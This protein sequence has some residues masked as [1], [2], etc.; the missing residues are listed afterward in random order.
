MAQEKTNPTN[1][2]YDIALLGV[3]FGANYGSLLNGYSV[4]KILKKMNRTV[5]MVHKIGAIPND[6]EI[7]GTHNARFVEKFYPDED[8]SP[9]YSFERLSELNNYCD[10]F[11]TG[12]DQVWQYG[13]NS[14][15]HM[16]FF[17]GFVNSDKRKISFGTSFGHSEDIT[18]LEKRHEVSKWLSRF[19]AISVREESGITI[20]RDIYG[21][22]ARTVIE[23]VFCVEKNEFEKLALSSSINETEP[24]ILAYILDPTPEKRELIIKYSKLSG[25]KFIIIL[26]GQPN[27]YQK[28]LELMNL[29]NCLTGIGAEDFIK[30]YQN[31]DFVI[32][33]SFHGTAFSIIFNKPFISIANR[34]RGITRFEDL[35][36][37]FGLMERLIYDINVFG[38]N[39]KQMEMFD[40][41][42]INTQIQ[43]AKEESLGWLKAALETPITYP[44]P[45][46]YQDITKQLDSTMCVG[47]SSCVAVCPKNALSLKPDQWG[48]Y[49]SS[50]DYRLCINCGKC[51]KVCPAIKL[52]EN[53]NTKT[54]DCYAF[55]TSDD[56][57]LQRSSSGG[58][59]T[60]L[61]REIFRQKGCVV[62]AAWTK[63]L[64]VEHIIIESEKDLWKLQ[65]SKYL[66]SYMGTTF[67]EIKK[68]LETGKKVLFTGTPCQTAGLRAFLGKDYE[69]L[70]IVDI[71]CSNAPSS[72]FFSKYM[73]DTFPRGIKQY[74]F[75]HK[76]SKKSWD[77]LTIRAETS[78]GQQIIQKG[79]AQDNF[80]RVF[81]NHTMCSHHCEK[82]KYQSLPRFGDITIGDFWGIEKHVALPDGGTGVSVVLL[83]STKGK[84]FFENK[85]PNKAILCKKVPLDWI[86]GNGYAIK[87]SHSYAPQSR[88][89]FFKAITKMSFSEAVNYA[90]KPNH[91]QYRNIYK[92]NKSALQFDCNMLH[93]HFEP[94]YWQELNIEGRP[95]LIVR[96]GKWNE[97]GHYARLSLADCLTIGQKYRF[98]IKFK[99]KSG[100]SMINFHIIDSGSK[101]L[102]IIHSENISG[103]N[104]GEQWIEISKDFIPNAIYYDEFMVGAAQVTGPN[105]FLT[106]AYI[107][108]SKVQ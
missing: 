86:G 84:S 91:G 11:M 14:Y 106:F 52:P 65:K 90:L 34:K 81:H 16:A 55:V 64:T 32:T 75:R 36:G 9:V 79:S 46:A 95:T 41:K 51:A 92:N 73:E 8:I 30:L 3:W 40:Y 82:C 6:R 22:K 98:S 74:E 26:D 66:Q 99:I 67:R 96:E 94:E 50:V 60:T 35:L 37:R 100:A 25:K 21:V 72:G 70:I 47:C 105:N 2:H 78:D 39:V 7:N 58:I 87:N 29:P 12:S 49:R 42:R 44:S 104:N 56:K 80:Q 107:N 38:P 77:C 43:E 10:T 4:Y 48:Y 18:P 45:I 19:Q 93:F 17:M 101:Q 31:T 24:Y 102:Q 71:F 103:R 57:V 53:Q 83:N 89:L 59:F 54:P 85:C 33:D 28:N 88:D 97:N 23:P 5:L 76:T 15:F 27:T 1:S 13:I 62:G 63:D 61:A 108:I 69:N 68:I 20:C